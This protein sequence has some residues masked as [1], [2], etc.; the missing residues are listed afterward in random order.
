MTTGTSGRTKAG[1]R[2]P[3]LDTFYTINEDGSR[4]FLHPADVRGRWQKRKNA[5][6]AILIVVYLAVP[7]IQINGNPAIWIDIAGRKAHLFGSTFTNQ[8]FYLFFF[9]L[10]GVGFALFV[11]T[12]LLGR[13]WCGYACPQTVYLE[14][15]FRRVERW[16]EGSREVRIRR[17]MAP[18]SF[19]KF[20]RKALKHSLFG[21]L[22]LV[23]A[24]A[25]VAYFLP[26]RHLVAAIGGS[27]AHHWTAFLWVAVMAGI[28]YFDF[29]WFREQTCLV[30]CP[31]GR[32]QGL[33]VDRDTLIIGY[34]R[35]R[36]EP[37]TKASDGGGGDCVDCGRCIAVCPTGIDIRN[38]VQMECI[39][40]A[41]CIDACDEVMDRLHRP[42]GLVRYD[43]Q[44]A[45]DG[46][47]RAFLR[48]RVYLYAVLGVLGLVAFMLVGSRRTTFEARALRSPGMPYV[49]DSGVIRNLYN[50]HLQNKEGERRV[51]FLKALAAAGD[52]A[53]AGVPQPEVLVSL[54][55]V[56]LDPF[57]S[58]Q[59]PV[60]ATLGL[61]AYR[62][63]I[64]LVVEV[65]DSLGGAVKR[66]EVHFLGP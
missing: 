18:M 35:R 40:C 12:A 15:V 39:G 29:A 34:D 27:P 16:L 21:I 41:N 2:R 55:R 10:S 8:D 47:P 7:W 62:E 65:A 36:G 4:N 38:G 37:R 26:A 59:V 48:P 25:F 56:V 63:P 3:D 64:P 60:F 17:N 20:W 11:L 30:V 23:I 19:D 44:R 42:R 61:D 66:V 24:H 9:I 50:I 6:F 53:A 14:G 33:L 1:T 45:F 31:Y 51:Y 28:L 32:L 57:A 43:S 22:S 46:S 54:H 13:V 5:L 58:V 49:I 52:G